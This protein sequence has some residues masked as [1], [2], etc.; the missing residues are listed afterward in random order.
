MGN[1]CRSPTAHGV[2]EQ[3]VNSKQLDQQILTDS[4]GTHSYH[5]GEAPDPRSQ[6]TAKNNG[7]DL[8]KQRARKVEVEDFDKFDY[9]IAMDSSNYKNLKKLA[10]TGLEYKV[11]RFMEFASDRSESDVPDPY[12]GGSNGFENVFQMVDSAS[13]GLLKHIQTSDLRS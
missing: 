10:P 12:Y 13:Q 11:H 6:A 4:A 5:I 9:I 1:I 8:S 3:L 7:V 2:F